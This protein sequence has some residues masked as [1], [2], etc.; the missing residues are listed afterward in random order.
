MWPAGRKKRSRG[1]HVTRGPYVVQACSKQTT[2]TKKTRPSPDHVLWRR[3]DSE[4]STL[5]MRKGCFRTP[6]SSDSKI[7]QP[8]AAARS[9]SACLSSNQR[10]RWGSRLFLRE[11]F[12]LFAV[13]IRRPPVRNK[14]WGVS[15]S[16]ASKARGTLEE[17]TSRRRRLQAEGKD[18]RLAFLRTGYKRKWEQAR[19][20]EGIRNRYACLWERRRCAV[21]HLSQKNVLAI[22]TR[23]V[24]CFTIYQQLTARVQYS[25]GAQ[26]HARD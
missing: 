13:A 7:L 4:R 15:P 25:T 12:S 18:P 3:A 24:K 20:E 6:H 19:A 22:P 16:R 21:V 14:A 5:Q 1:P 10:L 11:C 2:L 9:R 26:D 8:T 17:Q 23:V